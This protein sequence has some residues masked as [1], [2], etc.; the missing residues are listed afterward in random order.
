MFNQDDRLTEQQKYGI[1]FDDDYDYLQH[2][3]EPGAT[4]LEPVGNALQSGAARK[5]R[6]HNLVPLPSLLLL[7]ISDLCISRGVLYQMKTKFDHQEVHVALQ[8]RYTMTFAVQSVV[9]HA[10]LTFP[11]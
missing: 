1:Y 5:V 4:V 7:A 10:H 8:A 3:K 2:L 6:V 11:I 9:K